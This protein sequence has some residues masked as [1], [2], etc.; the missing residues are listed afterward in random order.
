VTTTG[1]RP[2]G[3]GDADDLARLVRIAQ[4]HFVERESQRDIAR[5][6]GVSPSTVS[7]WVQQAIDRGIV[8]FEIVTPTDSGQHE[9][10]GDRVSG[11]LGIRC[12]RIA[13]TAANRAA[14][15]LSVA[16]QASRLL[17]EMI[18]PGLTIGV[19][20]GRTVRDVADQLGLASAPVAAGSVQVVQLMGG[21]APVASHIQAHTVASDLAR[22][23]AGA[24]YL[25]H[26]PAIL[27]DRTSLAGLLSNRTVKH[28]TDLFRA[29]DVALVGVGSMGADS[30]LLG[31]GFLTDAEVRRLIHL[32]AVG[33]MC[34]RFIDADGAICDAELDARTLAVHLS[35]LVNG[36]DV[37]VAAFGRDKLAVI[38]AAARAGLLTVL[39]TDEATG[40][41]LAT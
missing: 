36:P 31:S 30:P 21:I 1:D 28:T 8:R 2:S 27:D 34:G 6:M 14:T 4:L 22:S 15:S 7:R 24:V 9:S 33:D 10:L 26:A 39:V 23:L 40:E 3:V 25:T 32:G 19:S 13:P 35:D 11:A 41:A 37:V 5:L 38:R 16:R 17:L 20:G 12:C 18:R 29:L